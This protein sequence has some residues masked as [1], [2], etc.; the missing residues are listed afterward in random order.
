MSEF[1]PAA[2]IDLSLSRGVLR[3]GEFSLKSG[4]VSPYFFNAG[5]LNDGEALSL[6]AR[7]YAQKLIEA[8]GSVELIFGP[9]YKGI[10]LVAATAATLSTVHGVNLPW[11]FNRKEA[12]DHGE[13]GVLVGAPVAGKKVWIIDDVITAGTAIREVMD[14]LQ[15][16]GAEVAGVLVALD[17]QERGQGERSAIQEIEQQHQIPVHALMTL[18]DLMNYLAA[19]DRQE[20]LARMQA[21]RNQYGV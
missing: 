14:L 13:G 10:P 11:G 20:D 8:G 6:L 7:G 18:T 2:L 9:A 1:T 15:N 3:F 16:A 17:R 19:Q 4:R 21:Y 12:K 5:L